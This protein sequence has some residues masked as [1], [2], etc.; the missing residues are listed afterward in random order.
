MK[1]SS[2][3]NCLRTF[4]SV[5]SNLIFNLKT[6]SHEIS[7]KLLSVADVL[8]VTIDRL[9]SRKFLLKKI[10]PIEP[11]KIRMK[12]NEPEKVRE[13]SF[14]YD[15]RPVH[16]GG[17]GANMIKSDNER[18]FSGFMSDKLPN[19]ATFFC[20]L[21]V[22]IAISQGKKRSVASFLPF[23]RPK[24]FLNLT[25]FNGFLPLNFNANPSARFQTANT[26]IMTCRTTSM[27]F[28]SFLESLIN[29]T[30]DDDDDDDSR[31]SIFSRC[32]LLPRRKKK[33]PEQKSQFV[34]NR[35]M[36]SMQH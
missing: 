11:F 23:S 28:S 26:I 21:P 10:V 29:H 34:T 20:L 7:S 31:A 22:V 9:N 1:I 19:V 14:Y 25:R 24:R 4:F 27:M 5:Q 35:A 12:V 16:E 30:H 17:E 2:D 13:R 15:S 32:A 6:F 33:K 8:L 36:I 3:E 18:L